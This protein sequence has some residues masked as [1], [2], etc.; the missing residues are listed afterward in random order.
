MAI[1]AVDSGPD[2]LNG[3]NEDDLI[4]GLADD[5]TLD[6]GSG[7]DMNRAGFAGG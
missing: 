5:D 3:T 1:I 7:D 2:N 4:E 6:G